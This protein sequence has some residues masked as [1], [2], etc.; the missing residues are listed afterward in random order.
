MQKAFGRQALARV[1]KSKLDSNVKMA[2]TTR[3]TLR[4][5]TTKT[6]TRKTTRTKTMTS[7]KYIQKFNHLYKFRLYQT[8]PA[9]LH[10]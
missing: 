2:H 3:K 8:N 10:H 5:K 6:M 4:T 9:E 7:I 1:L